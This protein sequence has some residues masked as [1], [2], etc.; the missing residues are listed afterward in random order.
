MADAPIEPPDPAEVLS[1]VRG[2][3]GK[4]E[5]LPERRVKRTREQWAADIQQDF[6]EAQKA[7]LQGAEKRIAAGKKLLA[8]KEE[9]GYRNF[10]AMLKEDLQGHERSCRRLMYIAANPV[11]S[12]VANMATLPPQITTLEIL[13]RS[14]SLKMLQRDIDQ[15][16]IHFEI[17]ARDAERIIR[18]H[19]LMLQLR[20]KRP[21]PRSLG[22][23]VTKEMLDQIASE[24]ES[25]YRKRI[26]EKREKIRSLY[27]EIHDYEK[28]IGERDEEED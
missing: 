13:A 18:R 24:M 5:K 27:R 7:Y 14:P 10:G 4:E 15:G 9:L 6:T 21:E 11:L 1:V 16:D 8:A 23:P 17:K 28:L 2:L 3:Q 19:E 25:H 22:R 26:V 12:N 20:P